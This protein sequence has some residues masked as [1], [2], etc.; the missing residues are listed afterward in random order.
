MNGVTGPARRGRTGHGERA[1]SAAA[2]ATLEEGVEVVAPFFYKRD[3]LGSI[4]GVRRIVDLRRSGVNAEAD[5]LSRRHT[6]DVQ[7]GETLEEGLEV[8][9]PFFSMRQGVSWDLSVDRRSRSRR[10]SRRRSTSF[11]S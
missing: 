7:G 3:A 10:R 5:A 1:K 6:D 2:R 8:V 4:A 11:S 9:S